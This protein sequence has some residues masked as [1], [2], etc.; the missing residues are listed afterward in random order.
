LLEVVEPDNAEE[1]R[2]RPLPLLMDRVGRGIPG[3]MTLLK[4]K[5][6]EVELSEM[7]ELREGT[8]LAKMPQPQDY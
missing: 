1:G 2:V 7:P 3:G 5:V 8:E 6:S 4:D